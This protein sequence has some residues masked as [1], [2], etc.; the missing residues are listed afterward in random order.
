MKFDLDKFSFIKKIG[1]LPQRYILLCILL[2]TSLMS[3]NLFVKINRFAVNILFSDQWDTYQPT[4]NNENLWR[5][6][7]AQIGQL[8]LGIGGLFSDFI[9][10]ATDWNTRA[11]SFAIGFSMVLISIFAVYL[12]YR[13]FRK[14]S[15]WDLIIPF[16]CLSVGK[17]DVPILVPFPSHS[18]MP[19]LLLILYAVC[20]TFEQSAI[21]IGLLSVI[22][23]LAIFT[24]W[25]LFVGFVTPFLLIYFFRHNRKTGNKNDFVWI[26][27]AFVFSILSLVFYFKDYIVYSGVECFTLPHYPLTDYWKFLSLMLSNS[28]GFGCGRKIY[29]SFFL[30]TMVFI[31]FVSTGILNLWKVL[32]RGETGD[33]N[34]NLVILVLLAFSGLFIA[35]ATIGRTCLGEC[36]ATAGRYQTLLIPAWLAVYFAFSLMTE[37]KIRVFAGFLLVVFCFIFPQSRDKTYQVSAEINRDIKNN[38]KACYLATENAEECDRKVGTSIFAP[39]PSVKANDRF[40]YLRQRKLNFYSDK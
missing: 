2:A 9:A 26:A 19:I 29:L 36:N 37:N 13:L 23:F 27:S 17:L 10:R 5:I 40:E 34:I 15:L 25:G 31:A 12:K 20:L 16:V 1:E 39:L 33:R 35:T 3:A 4:F 14:L 24:G 6:F 22:N 18:T 30:G 38:W 11:E 21:R 8:R 28:I 32:R 7:T